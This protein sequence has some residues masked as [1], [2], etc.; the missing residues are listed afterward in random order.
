M[1]KA[2][3]IITKYVN[4][5]SGASFDSLREAEK[6]EDAWLKNKGIHFFD[7]SLHEINFHS[8]YDNT[9]SE[10]GFNYYVEAIYFDSKEAAKWFN[11]EFLTCLD[12]SY[13]YSC[14]KH[15]LNNFNENE[16][17]YIVDDFDPD[18]DDYCSYIPFSDYS[19]HIYILQK[20]VNEWENKKKV[21]DSEA[22]K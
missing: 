22:Q 14:N 7:D 13:G 21:L 16:R 3:T 4:S 1:R 11:E 20:Y 10:L 18:R 17:L 5:F 8:F 2:E 6:D 12:E 9:S 15:M 19:A